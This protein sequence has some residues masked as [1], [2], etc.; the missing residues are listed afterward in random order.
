MVAPM[1]L[2][3]DVPTATT[4]GMC[5]VRARPASADNGGRFPFERYDFEACYNT[6]SPTPSGLASNGSPPSPTT[7]DLGLKGVPS[8][9]T[10]GEESSC[11]PDM[12][13]S[14]KHALGAGWCAD[15]RDS[16]STNRMRADDDP[17]TSN[18]DTWSEFRWWRLNNSGPEEQQGGSKPDMQPCDEQSG[19]KDEKLQQ[20]GSKSDKQLCVKTIRTKK[21]QKASA[22]PP[23]FTSAAAGAESN[24]RYFMKKTGKP[25]GKG[26]A[27]SS[28]SGSGD[29]N[30]MNEDAGMGSAGVGN[31]NDQNDGDG[32]GDGDDG[33]DSDG[34]GDESDGDGDDGN[35]SDRSGDESDE[36][37]DA[38]QRRVT[39]AVAHLGWKGCFEVTDNSIK[40][41]FNSMVLG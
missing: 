33:N 29:V 27:P 2:F 7:A 28:P 8:T 35:D 23:K 13:A 20:R 26:G 18:S 25:A 19:G 15:V 16:T 22:Q 36:D 39:G 24:G 14:G 9:D 6:E 3:H 40:V 1:R 37:M 12:R 34:S 10:E 32:D 11:S 38:G 41:A 30:S 4:A 17:K 31:E 5:S 21:V